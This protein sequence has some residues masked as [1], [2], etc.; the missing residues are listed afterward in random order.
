M[1]QNN[2]SCL[3]LTMLQFEECIVLTTVS[4]QETINYVSQ[5][6]TLSKTTLRKLTICTLKTL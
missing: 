3:N 4:N 5:L 6:S 1:D 2:K